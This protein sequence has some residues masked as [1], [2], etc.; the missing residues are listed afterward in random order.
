M[1][2]SLILSDSISFSRILCLRRIFVLPLQVMRSIAYSGALYFHFVRPVLCP[3]RCPSRANIAWPSGRAA[4]VIGKHTDHRPAMLAVG[5]HIVRADKSIS[6]QKWNS[7]QGGQVHCV[8]KIHKCC[9]GGIKWAPLVFRFVPSCT[10]LFS[11]FRVL[12]GKVRSPIERQWVHIASA[13]SCPALRHGVAIRE[14]DHRPGPLLFVSVYF[15]HTSP[16]LF[17]TT[18]NISSTNSSR[19]LDTI[20]IDH[21]LLKWEA[22]VD[23]PL[24]LFLTRY[25]FSSFLRLLTSSTVDD[26]LPFL[27]HSRQRPTVPVHDMWTM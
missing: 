5:Q 7:P 11:T 3:P 9:C 19:M 24:L 27:P 21:Q 17:T 13:K 14:P 12:L 8:S 16:Y 20:V 4:L 15:I 25:S 26:P 6:V 10:L 23:S 1:V 2:R 18:A 22:L